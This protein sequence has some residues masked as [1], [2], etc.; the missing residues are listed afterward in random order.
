MPRRQFGRKTGVSRQY[1]MLSSI[2][3]KRQNW[4]SSILI[5]IL[6]PTSYIMIIF[7][8]PTSHIL[9]QFLHHL[10]PAVLGWIRYV[11]TT[12]NEF[13]SEQIRMPIRLLYPVAPPEPLA[14]RLVSNVAAYIIFPNFTMGLRDR[15]ATLKIFLKIN[16]YFWN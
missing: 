9:Y 12:V 10:F 14:D 7:V 3:S 13:N 16:F 4:T 11:P 6:H 2:E 15:D 8:E 5:V 1:K